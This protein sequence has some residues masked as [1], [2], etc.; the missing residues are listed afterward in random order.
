[1]QG[2]REPRAPRAVVEEA[3]RLVEEGEHDRALELVERRLEAPPTGGEVAALRAYTL[4]WIH[5]RIALARGDA[6]AEARAVA[7]YREAIATPPPEAARDEKV[8]ASENLA[9]LLR[10]Q[11][12]LE[13]AIA[14]LEAIP[15]DWKLPEHRLAVADIL[16]R[17]GRFEEAASVFAAVHRLV[18]EDVHTADR[19][20]HTFARLA[21]FPTDE[22]LELCDSFEEHGLVTQELAGLELVLQALAL[23]P[24]EPDANGA[25]NAV[26]ERWLDRSLESDAFSST[27]LERLPELE[28]SALSETRAFLA[29]P[30][31]DLAPEATHWSSA[32]A[33]ALLLARAVRVLAE[34]RELAGQPALALDR[35]GVAAALLDDTHADDRDS[36]DPEVITLAVEIALDRLLLVE[37]YPSLEGRDLADE[38]L[39]QPTLAPASIARVS[40]EVR[41]RFHTVLGLLFA[42]R[43]WWF[44]GEVSGP[45]APG[46]L[47]APLWRSAPYHLEQAVVAGRTARGQDASREPL[48]HLMHILAEGLEESGHLEEAVVAHTRAA[49]GYEQ[50]EELVLA[51]RSYR[52]ARELA[53]D[54]RRS[55]ATLV[56]R[57]RDDVRLPG[58]EWFPLDFVQP[59][60][61]VGGSFGIADGNVGRG[62]SREHE[63]DDGLGFLGH[64]TDTSLDDREPA[65][66]LRIGYQF[67]A[68]VA[69]E[70]GWVELGEIDS[71]ITVNSIDPGPHPGM[72]PEEKFLSD[73]ERLHP[74][75]AGGF[76]AGLRANVYGSGPFTATTSGG[77]WWWDADIEVRIAGLMPS[78]TTVRRDGFDPFFGV[79]FLY[80][81]A[82]RLSLRGDVEA[83]YVDGDRLDVAT[84]GLQFRF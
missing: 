2:L 38:I 42:N 59:G 68:P 31:A 84:L 72:T 11:G 52:R 60:W 77:I 20:L 12:R 34:E 22:A 30:T 8:D 16:F 55:N 43:G 74:I 46:G 80:E 83:F 10:R 35:L 3:V 73:A 26:F 44:V 4:G 70:L 40:P 24:G 57:T 1:V 51:R 76:S 75:L 82:G 5:A 21:P 41:E 29:E 17:L 64:D 23:D 79:G 18:P 63:F 19:A 36:A 71:R 15:D 37:D 53:R 28:G 27:R 45:A 32:R 58:G 69:I 6:A 48:P 9:I 61:F 47:P 13:E 7:Y 66:R 49:R 56:R 78:K 65:G 14:V 25:A 33:R 39:A 81:L 62:E 50:Q 67:D 54:T